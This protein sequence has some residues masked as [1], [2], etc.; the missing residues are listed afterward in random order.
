MLFETVPLLTVLVLSFFSPISS[1]LD[2]SGFENLSDLVQRYLDIGHMTSFVD[3]IWTSIASRLI[4]YIGLA[5]ASMHLRIHP[6]L[7]ESVSTF[8][9]LLLVDIPSTTLVLPLIFIDIG[10]ISTLTAYPA[11][12]SSIIDS[13]A[14]GALLLRANDSVTSPSLEGAGGPTLTSALSPNRD[15][16]GGIGISESTRGA[17][18]FEDE[19][20]TR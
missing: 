10:N 15:T 12:R 2:V 13:F 20:F 3:A 16:R 7:L 4:E 11:S 14:S 6:Y 8:V 18:R 19:R 9:D 5:I 1:T 17:F